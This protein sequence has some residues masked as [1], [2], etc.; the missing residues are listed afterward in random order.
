MTN[1][2]Q[3]TENAAPFA[4][5]IGL[6][7]EGDLVSILA[8]QSEQLVQLFGGVSEEQSHYRYDEGKW[9]IRE[10]LGHVI[11]NERV[12]TYRLLRTARGDQL[13]FPSYNQDQFMQNARFDEIPLSELLDEFVSLRK[14]T[15]YLLK[16]LPAEA[17]D[18]AG[19]L[20]DHPLSVRAAAAV[21][22]GHEKHHRNIIRERYLG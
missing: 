14:S 9:S 19:T 13:S 20:Y 18:R 2:P 5:Y 17:W 10:V 7:P 12:W 8:E 4:K 15:I 16:G 6:V 1:K 11:D 3:T 21:I 22:A